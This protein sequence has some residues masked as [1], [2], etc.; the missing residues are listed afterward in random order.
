MYVE[1]ASCRFPVFYAGAVVFLILTM[2]E[3]FFFSIQ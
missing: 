2:H 3:F 1:R